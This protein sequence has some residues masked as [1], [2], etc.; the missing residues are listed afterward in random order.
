MPRKSETLGLIGKLYYL[1]QKKYHCV[2]NQGDFFEK[3]VNDKINPMAHIIEYDYFTKGMKDIFADRLSCDNQ[4]NPDLTPLGQWNLKY[5]IRENILKNIGTNHK[6]DLNNDLIEIL[7]STEDYG[8]T[9]QN[10]D[11]TCKIT[12]SY[13]DDKD[14][15]INYIIRHDDYQITSLEYH[16]YLLIYLAVFKQLPRNFEFGNDYKEHL[17]EFNNEVTCRY[18]VTSDPGR[19]TI[20]SMAMRDKPNLFALYEYADMLYYGVSNGPD[21]NINKAFDCYKRLT[22]KELTNPLAY[23]SLAYIYFNY[24]QP[25]TSLEK[26]ESIPELEKMSRFEQVDYATTEA[27]NSLKAVKNPAAANILGKIL[28]ISEEDLPNISIIKN[29]IK[30]ITGKKDATEL[31]LEAAN[32]GYSYAYGNLA[33]IYQRK[34]TNGD[35]SIDNLNKYLKYLSMQA[36]THEPWALNAL[37]NFYYEGMVDNVSYPGYADPDL[38][39][40]YYKDAIESFKDINSGWAYANL[41]TKFPDNYPRTN[42]NII[43]NHV[44]KLVETKNQKA[45]NMVKEKLADVYGKKYDQSEL[46]SLL[47]ILNSVEDL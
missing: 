1:F 21:R 39:K 18:G 24:H 31:F 5:N 13:S 38:A 47:S 40:K 30:K 15:L 12:K 16:I 7:T 36:E 37:G 20:I 33:K 32:A 26:C 27:I 25:G 29:R 34:I 46:N 4:D 22:S 6:M 14:D 44:L 41:I 3:L 19:R 45:I 11:N 28:Q 9:N 23:W 43:I 17:E 2:K 10:N 35:S 42:K 8:D